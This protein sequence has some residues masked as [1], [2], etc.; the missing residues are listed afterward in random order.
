MIVAG[1]G[2]FPAPCR[3][4]VAEVPASGPVSSAFDTMP[5]CVKEPHPPGALSFPN[6]EASIIVSNLRQQRRRF[7][8]PIVPYRTQGSLE[9]G[10]QKVAMKKIKR[11]PLRN[12]WR[13]LPKAG[14]SPPIP[15]GEIVYWQGDD[16]DAVFYIRRGRVKIT[17]LSPTGKEAVIA[18]LKADEFFGEGCLIEQTKR[19][20]ICG[21]H[22]RMRDHAG[23]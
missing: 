9:V 15:R 18:L 22:H 4:K 1:A 10:G 19:S 7:H 17:V 20:S 14:L 8:G 6:T 5:V 13:R 21:H 2:E 23:R 12:F 11:A 16:A 3:R